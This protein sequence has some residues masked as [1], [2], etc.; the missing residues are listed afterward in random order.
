MRDY[1]AFSVSAQAYKAAIMYDKPKIA[2]TVKGCVIECGSRSRN[3]L[4]KI[5]A[6]RVIQKVVAFYEITRVFII[7]TSSFHWTIS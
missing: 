4:D 1:V 3:F 6:S 7:F 5:T 2:I